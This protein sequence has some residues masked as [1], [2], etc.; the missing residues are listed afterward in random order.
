[1]L[2]LRGTRVQSLAGELRSHILPG[3]PPPP[4]PPL[5]KKEKGKNCLH[6]KGLGGLLPVSNSSLDSLLEVEASCHFHKRQVTHESPF[7]SALYF[8]DLCVPLP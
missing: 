1:M 8:R 5:P 6:L 4:P 2:P 3:I 7:S